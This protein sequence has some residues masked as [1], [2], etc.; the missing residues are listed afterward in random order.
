M[1]KHQY[2]KHKEFKI[3]VQFHGYNLTG[4]NGDTMRW[5]ACVEC[6]KG[7]IQA[8]WEGHVTN[9]WRWRHLFVR[10][11]SECIELRLGMDDELS[12]SF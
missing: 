5:L 8:L 11:A 4:M 7:G 6:C 9:T 1:N 2:C 3:Y 12:E 10:E